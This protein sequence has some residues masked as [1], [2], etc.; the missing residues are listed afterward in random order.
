MPHITGTELAV[1]IKE[2]ETGDTRH[3]PVILLSAEHNPQHFAKLLEERIIS[4]YM[5]KPF[6]PK[7]LIS[8]IHFLLKQASH[9]ESTNKLET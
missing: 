2:K 8:L 5:P 7:Q 3:I 4:S 1:F 6:Q 9:K